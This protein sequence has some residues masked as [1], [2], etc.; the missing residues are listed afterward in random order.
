M[1]LAFLYQVVILALFHNEELFMK[2]WLDHH[3]SI[4]VEHFYLYDHESTDQS[5]KILE[6]YIEKGLV[7]L[8]HYPMKITT[9][10]EYIHKLQL[11]IYR[12]GLQKIK[13]IAKWAA[14][15]DIDE[16]IV[17]KSSKNLSFFLKEYEAYGALAINWQI[18]G[19]TKF[20][21]LPQEKLTHTFLWKAPQDTALHQS[22]KMI[23]QVNHV[24]G[25]ENP[26]L[27]EFSEKFPAVTSSHQKLK[28]KERFTSS[29]NIDKIQL[30]HYW[31]GTK[32][33]FYERKLP[34]LKMW[35]R[36][37]SETLIQDLFSFY[38][39]CYDPAILE[40]EAL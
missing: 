32:K 27:F 26:H 22:I 14:F 18:F 11:P 40:I 12:D 36:Q 16:F 9:Q 37:F 7:D 17:P 5:R 30:N 38:T 1:I 4:G 13:G 29:I 8:I 15:I 31:F 20:S 2:E 21:L 19:P 33:W 10:E 35:G 28:P 3:L 23:A 6:P 39:Q 25:I 34:R 24:I